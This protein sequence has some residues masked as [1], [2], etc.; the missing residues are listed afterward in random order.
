V[1]F[2]YYER[3]TRRQQR[4]YR[5]SDEI[6]AIPIPGVADLCPLVAAVQETLA[7]GDRERTQAAADRLLPPASEH[8]HDG[9]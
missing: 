5:Q 2:A 4:V 1:P 8:G 3:L 7:S 9:R 6:A